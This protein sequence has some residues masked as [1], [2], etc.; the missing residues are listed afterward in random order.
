MTFLRPALIISALPNTISNGQ[1][2]DATP[3]MADL[4]H[5]VNQVNANAAGLTNI[6]LLNATNTFTQPQF[7]APAMSSTHVPIVQQIQDMSFLTLSSIMGT[8]TLTGRISGMPLPA[9]ANGQCFTFIPSRTN[10]GAMTL[11][12]DGLGTSAMQLAGS[13]VRLGMVMQSLPVALRY[14][15]PNFH[16]L[17]NSAMMPMASG[18]VVSNNQVLVGA[19]GAARGYST[20]T[21]DGIGLTAS[22]TGPHIFGGPIRRNGFTVAGLPAGTQ[23]DSAYVTDAIAPVFLGALTGGGTVV[24]PVFYNG[25]AWVAE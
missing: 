12:I 4:N 7:S 15:S 22:G 23:G 2:A 3:V 8:D 25:T 18:V 9:Y 17:S 13:D 6:A 19:Q 1:V 5:I 16:V 11:R 20:L 21:F 24:T 14:Q 10:S